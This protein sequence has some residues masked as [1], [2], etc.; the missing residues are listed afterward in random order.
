MV[1]KADAL[2]NLVS[3]PTSSEKAA[4]RKGSQRAQRL[5]RK[6]PFKQAAS[7]PSNKGDSRMRMYHLRESVLDVTVDS[8]ETISL[9]KHILGETTPWGR[10]I[11][12]E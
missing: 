10:Q 9:E 2:V 5:G 11:T 8:A 6:C 7:G 3:V 4:A 12:T 1:K